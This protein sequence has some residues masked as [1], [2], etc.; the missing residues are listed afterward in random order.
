MSAH[1]I[2]YILSRKVTTFALIAVCGAAAA[3]CQTVTVNI[4]PGIDI[5]SV[6]DASP[7]G[8]TFMIHP[9]VYRMQ[10]I[11]PKSG[12]IFIG[13]SGAILN[14]SQLLTSFSKEIVNGVTYWFAKGPS[15]PGLLLDRCDDKFPMCRYPE[16]LYIDDK[17]LL[18]ASGLSSI[19]AGM[20][21]Y[22]YSAGKIFF[23]DN[24]IGHTVETSSTPVAFETE[25]MGR[26]YSNITI[27]GLIIEKY[28]TPG[29]RS[30][31]GGQYGGSNWIVENNEVRL[32]HGEGVRAGNGSQ[33]LNNYIH[34]NGQLGIGISEITTAVLVQNNEISRN[35]WAGFRKTFESGGVKFGHVVNLTARG[36]YI[37]DNA[38]VG[39]WCDGSCIGG[40]YENNT[41][42]NNAMH[43]ILH[44]ISHN[45]T[46]RN[47]VIIG[48]GG[49]GIQIDESDH[50]EVA[51][52]FVANNYKTIAMNMSTRPGASWVDLNNN[53]VHDNIIVTGGVNGI[54]GI[55]QTM[56]NNAYYTIKNN[57]FANDTY[58]MPASSRGYYWWMNWYQT[59]EAW[60]GYGQDVNGKWA[61]PGVYISSPS[62]AATLSGKVLVSTFAA[63]T[64]SVTKVLYY[65][66]GALVGTST[67]KASTTSPYTYTWDT[68]KD[69]NGRHILKAQAYNQDGQSSTSS[70]TVT[71]QNP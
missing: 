43:G 31:I 55:Y 37:H 9:G 21:Y 24:P 39:L 20:C 33:V 45:W 67:S 56:N 34:D 2:W 52:N 46:I 68:T 13:E 7:A 30:T 22:D 48:N 71:V 5:P 15:Q 32:N 64:V 6:V 51:A 44:E 62:N 38:G 25:S 14:G 10:M 4:L 19:T 18:R 47:N 59:T 70:V 63:D 23:L 57:R 1:S 41:V 69:I 28:A 66:D 65:V 42:V 40:L 27:R 8:T 17:P 35:N 16:N 26:F 3:V 36:N 61:C 60:K 53:Y 54:T 50:V 29:Q 12:D 11:I 58:C 49:A